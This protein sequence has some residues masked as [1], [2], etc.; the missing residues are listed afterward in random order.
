MGDA[1]GNYREAYPYH[2]KGDNPMK[3]KTFQF[4]VS[5]WQ[6]N[7]LHPKGEGGLDTSAFTT[8]KAIDAEVNAWISKNVETLHDIKTTTYAVNRHN[9]GKD[10]TVILVYT[11]TYE[12]KTTFIAKVK[13]K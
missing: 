12:P 11:L 8:E 9:N 4:K 6:G 2:N 1:P 13:S 10:D 3:I 5:Y 7:T